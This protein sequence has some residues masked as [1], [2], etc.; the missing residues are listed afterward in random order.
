MD[1]IGSHEE[2]LADVRIKEGRVRAFLDRDVCIVI[3]R[4]VQDSTLEFITIRGNIG[5]STCKRDPERC[6]ASY[7][8]SWF[9]FP[10]MRMNEEY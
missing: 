3:D 2:V 7:S 5:S 8:H 9:T 6:L 10:R 4:S 1:Q